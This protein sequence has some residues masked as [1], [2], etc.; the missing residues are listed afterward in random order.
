MFIRAPKIVRVG[1]KVEV[2]AS[3]NGRAVFA[4]EDNILVTTF[5]PELAEDGRAHALFVEMTG[6]ELETQA[7]LVSI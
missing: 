2:L 7:T 3:L 5:H 6:A 1:P 4:R